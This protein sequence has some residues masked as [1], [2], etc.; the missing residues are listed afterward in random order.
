MELVITLYNIW[1]A[2]WPFGLDCI[3]TSIKFTRYGPVT[4]EP[5]LLASFIR[6]LFANSSI[7]T[8]CIVRLET[9][10]NER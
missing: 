6:N 10:G 1:E 5:K 7:I 4:E 9:R 8:C 3:S 2:R